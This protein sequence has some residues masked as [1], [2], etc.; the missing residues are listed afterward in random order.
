MSMY[1]SVLFLVVT[2]AVVIK[3]GRRQWSWSP[4]LVE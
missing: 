4:L 1:M 2:S 3:V